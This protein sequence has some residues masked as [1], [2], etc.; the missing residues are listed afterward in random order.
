MFI[1]TQNLNKLQLNPISN[2]PGTVRPY[3]SG[4]HFLTSTA[5][6]NAT[7]LHDVQH[8]TQSKNGPDSWPIC[9]TLEEY[10]SVQFSSGTFTVHVLHRRL[11]QL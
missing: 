9:S 2:S 7:T 5:C 11:P 4:V 8:K 1:A 3:L 6:L 10:L